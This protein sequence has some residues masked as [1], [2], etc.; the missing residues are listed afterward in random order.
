MKIV[1][2]IAAAA[3][4]L[5]FL[6]PVAHAEADP[7]IPN[8]D[9]LW[10]WGGKGTMNFVTPYCNGQ[11]FPDGSYLH[12]TGFMRG[13]LQPLGWNAPFCVNAAGAPFPEG[14]KS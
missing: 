11:P 9:A 10:C 4:G 13:M 8:G 5:L 7:S 3:A 14:C 6:S 1:S 12:Q 2:A